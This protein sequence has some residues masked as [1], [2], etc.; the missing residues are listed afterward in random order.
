MFDQNNASD[1]DIAQDCH[2]RKCHA[3][4]VA[5]YLP[6]VSRHEK[7][8]NPGEKCRT[9]YT[10]TSTT[11]TTTA[12]TRNGDNTTK[13]EPPQLPPQQ[14]GFASQFHA[15]A[16]YLFRSLCKLSSKEL[17]A[18]TVDESTKRLFQSIIPT[19]PTELNSKLLALELIVHALG[20]N[21]CGEAFL[22]DKFVYLVQHYLSGSLLKNCVS[23]H[24]KVAFLSQRIFLILL[25]K[26]KDYLKQDIE[27]F[28]SNVFFRV[29][30]SPNSSF[31]QK[32]LVLESLRSLCRDPVLL[33]QIFLNYDCDFDGMN[34]Y[35][36]I[37]H[38]LTK[39][40]G[41]ATTGGGLKR[42]T[43]R[44]RRNRR[45]EFSGFGMSRG[46]LTCFFKSPWFKCRWRRRWFHRF[47]GSADP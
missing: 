1:Y 36:D 47:G 14:H 24:T 13:A 26:F 39:L 33:T 38:T 6:R 12:T 41:R 27:I 32:A 35:K 21:C 20:D 34:L 22:G 44:I 31:K 43:T 29:L 30:E 16:Y 9:G 10:T 42:G 40:G 7:L 15:D 45:I 19:D 2:S 18:D 37:V 4:G 5:V 3:H 17:Q 46:D 11:A 28:M 25:Y 23:N 8:Q